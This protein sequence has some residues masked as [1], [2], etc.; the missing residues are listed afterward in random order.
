MHGYPPHWKIYTI[1]QP[2]SQWKIVEKLAEMMAN[3]GELARIRE[4]RSISGQYFQ[5]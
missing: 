5:Y 3:D 1:P 2:E 4:L